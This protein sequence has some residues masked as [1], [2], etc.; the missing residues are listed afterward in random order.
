M[1]VVVVGFARMATPL[2]EL[3]R[4]KSIVAAIVEGIENRYA[5]DGQRNG[6]AIQG[7]ARRDGIDGGRGIQRNLPCFA[8]VV[9]LCQWYLP[10]PARN[11]YHH[12]VA[13]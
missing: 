8:A 11:A 9:G 2:V 7:I 5:V 6:A 3:T 12:V 13:W 1:V 10:L 4:Q